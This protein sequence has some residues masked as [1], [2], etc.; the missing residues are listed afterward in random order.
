[1][2]HKATILL[3]NI[4]LFYSVFQCKQHFL[5][6]MR[7]PA[8]VNTALM[9][10]QSSGGRWVAGEMVKLNLRRMGWW[11]GRQEKSLGETTGLQDRL[12]ATLLMDNPS[13]RAEGRNRYWWRPTCWQQRA[14]QGNYHTGSDVGHFSR[15]VDKAVS[16]GPD[17]WKV[18]LK[19]E[20]SLSETFFWHTWDRK[21]NNIEKVVLLACF[22][23]F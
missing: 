6:S 14:A 17:Q 21:N 5:I 12:P 23:F 15:L 10:P 9:T 13:D 11:R 7:G 2:V 3:S 16:L 4:M 22:F 8:V 1:M 19:K 18:I 20:E